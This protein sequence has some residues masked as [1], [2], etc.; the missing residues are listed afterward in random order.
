[1]P[2]RVLII[3]TDFRDLP[4]CG[5]ER[6][7]MNRLLLAFLAFLTVIGG[8]TAPLLW[9]W[10]SSRTQNRILAGLLITIVIVGGLALWRST[11]ENPS[12]PHV[13]LESRK[14]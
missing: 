12:P 8:L 1:M 10:A 7:N 5:G 9:E 2:A 4:D 13:P 6:V 14:P 11:N 3:G